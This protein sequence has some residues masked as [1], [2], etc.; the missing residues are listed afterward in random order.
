MLRTFLLI[1]PI[2]ALFI[3]AIYY[4]VFAWN[5]AGDTE[6]DA[7]GYVAMVLGVVFSLAL[8]GVLIA[9]LLRRN[10]DED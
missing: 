1:V 2:A 3:V 10:R 4:M 8:A 9:L 7:S 5:S 6:M